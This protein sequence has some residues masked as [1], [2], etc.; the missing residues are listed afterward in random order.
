MS[1][2]PLQCTLEQIHVHTFQELPDIL[3]QL[4]FSLS[5]SGFCQAKNWIR[6]AGFSSLV[7]DLDVDLLTA[8]ATSSH[9]EKDAE[10]QMSSWVCWMINI[11]VGSP[12]PQQNGDWSQTNAN[13]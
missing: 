12:S 1:E 7:A 11:Q 4:K 5:S 8:M 13:P 2:T 3:N 6:A 10:A 9:L